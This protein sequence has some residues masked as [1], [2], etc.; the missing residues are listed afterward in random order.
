MRRSMTNPLMLV[1]SR[2]RLKFLWPSTTS[3]SLWR[4]LSPNLNLSAINVITAMNG[5]QSIS[6]NYKQLWKWPAKRRK[7]KKFSVLHPT[8]HQALVTTKKRRIC[9][10]SSS[11]DAK[12]VMLITVLTVS[13][14]SL[15]MSTSTYPVPEGTTWLKAIPMKSTS[16]KRSSYPNAVS[17]KDSTATILCMIETASF[18]CAKAVL[19]WNSS[20]RNRF[21]WSSW[22]KSLLMKLYWLFENIKEIKM[23]KD[24][25]DGL[26]EK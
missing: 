17:A 26:A 21:D 2:E 24:H 1:I 3:H 19:S 5:I 13:I 15:L 10:L 14:R 7:I 16:K 20:R 22:I 6:N 9:M 25:R 4:T 23:R 18:L 12:I 8:V 11:I